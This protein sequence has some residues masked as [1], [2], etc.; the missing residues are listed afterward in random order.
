MKY[1]ICTVSSSSR[2]FN[3]HKHASVIFGN[4]NYKA[5]INGFNT[6]YLYNGRMVLISIYRHRIP[7]QNIRYKESEI[8]D[9]KIEK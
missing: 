9:R 3:K 1:K 4:A 2:T 7:S 8:T 6:S 5:Y